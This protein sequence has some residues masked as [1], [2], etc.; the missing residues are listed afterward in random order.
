M[1]TFHHI[2]NKDMSI[3]PEWV[4][5][6]EQMYIFFMSSFSWSV[7]A[8]WHLWFAC[9]IN[10]PS[11]HEARMLTELKCGKIKHILCYSCTAVQTICLAWITV[12]TLTHLKWWLSESLPWMLN[13]FIFTGISWGVWSIKD[14]PCQKKHWGSLLWP[15]CLP[16]ASFC[17]WSDKKENSLH[18][19]TPYGTIK[20]LDNIMKRR[21]CD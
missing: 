1:T 14:Q 21:G 15:E 20:P 12:C 9:S 8:W 2:G 10:L 17:H 16:P 3:L 7:R 11:K 6:K 5:Q 19:E 4:V 13:V 18:C